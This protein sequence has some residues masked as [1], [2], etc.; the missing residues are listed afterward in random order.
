[1]GQNPAAEKNVDTSRFWVISENS[2]QC[3]Q[4]IGTSRRSIFHAPESSQMP[5][6]AKI[7][8]I[9]NFNNQIENS[10]EFRPNIDEYPTLEFPL[11]N[12]ND[13]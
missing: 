8:K 9:Y 11:V 3:R 5:Y 13:F 6:T 12:I 2:K 7:Q 1:M 10:L 4:I